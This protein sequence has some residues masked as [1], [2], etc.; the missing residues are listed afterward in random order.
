MGRLIVRFES[1]A[2]EDEVGVSVVYFQVEDDQAVHR[3]RVRVIE[4]D[5]HLEI[6]TVEGYSGQVERGSFAR[7]V[8]RVYREGVEMVSRLAN[9]TQ[10]ESC[11]VALRERDLVIDGPIARAS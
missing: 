9:V 2:I 1:L 8:E 6:G 3:C 4:R 11:I 10:R 5:A 7:E